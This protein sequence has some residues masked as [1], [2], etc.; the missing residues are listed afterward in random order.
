MVAIAPSELPILTAAL[1]P[2]ITDLVVMPAPFYAARDS[3][4][5]A[6]DYPLDELTDFARTYPN[7]ADAAWRTLNYFDPRWFAP[8]VGASTRLWSDA[9]GAPW[10]REIAAPLAN[11][12]S[13]PVELRE[14][15][16]SRYKDCLYQET[17]ICRRI[18]FDDV[19]VPAVWR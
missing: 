5:R 14:S 2:S 9:D 17:W 16:H 13:G 7:R 1:V 11:A 3:A 19:I 6:G 12:L 18:G 8:R 15:E 4:P 10:D